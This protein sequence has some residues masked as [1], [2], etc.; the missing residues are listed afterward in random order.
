MN[1]I[2]SRVLP[3]MN[4]QE[5]RTLIYSSYEQDAQTLT[6][7]AESNMLKF[8][9][10]TGQLSRDQA[11]RWKDIKKTFNRNLLLGTDSQDNVGRIIGQLNAF[12]VGLESIKDT[13]ADGM[14]QITQQKT[15]SALIQQQSEQT[16][17]KIQ[18]LGRMVLSRMNDMIEAIRTQQQAVLENDNI[19]TAQQDFRNNQMLVSVLEEQFR[20]METW[21][22]P[23]HH[24]KADRR[25]Y[26]EHLLKRF[27]TMVDGYSRLIEALR[28]KYDSFR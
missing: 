17:E 13:I 7:G 15:D 16:E 4:D 3:V 27:Q 14:H 23:V 26:F 5:L 18:Q 22:V 20:T 9:E 21:L 2:G 1:R 8:R 6:T 11:Q 28:E 19:Q 25:A 12:S 10:L 24:E